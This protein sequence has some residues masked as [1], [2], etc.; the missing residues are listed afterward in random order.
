MSLTL[1]LLAGVL[2]AGGVYLL[3]DRLLTRIVL[4][5]SLLGHGAVVLLIASGPTGRPPFAEGATGPAADPLP[6]ALALTAIVITFGILAFVLALALRSWLLT[7]SDAVPDDVEDRRV[8]RLRGRTE[9]PGEAPDPADAGTLPSTAPSA[10][11]GREH[12]SQDQPEV[13]T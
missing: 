3:L 1:A 4:G 13:D 2:F 7:G 11:S 9:D 10:A 6:Q 8:A 12:T 5:L